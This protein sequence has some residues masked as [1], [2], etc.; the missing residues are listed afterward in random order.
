MVGNIVIVRFPYT[1]MSSVGLRPGLLVADVR[2]GNQLDWVVC[3]I[4]TQSLPGSGQIPLAPD[5]LAFGQLSQASWVR[6]NRLM[7]MN[8][9]ILGNTIARL[10]DAKLSEILAA[11][12]SLF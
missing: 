11:V 6:P 8:Q 7:T 3:R 12:R 9:S 4:T 1:D 10:T 5:D 2:Y